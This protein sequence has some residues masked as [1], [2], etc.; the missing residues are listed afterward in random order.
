[1]LLQSKTLEV[2][3]IQN[4]G[5]GLPGS[6]LDISEAIETVG[7]VGF[8]L[9]PELTKISQGS[10]G[11]KLIDDTSGT[12]WNWLQSSLPSGT[13][14]LP[15]F[16]NIIVAGSPVFYGVINIKN[17]DRSIQNGDSS[18]T[19][20]AQDWPNMLGK[21]KLSGE[22]YSRQ[23]PQLQT[24]RVSSS[25]KAGTSVSKYTLLQ[26]TGFFSYASLVYWPGANDWLQEGDTL[27]CD[28]AAGT[29]R[30]MLV[31]TCV[32]PWP[33]VMAPG[34]YTAAFLEGFVW[35]T[36]A[37]TF[38]YYSTHQGESFTGNFTRGSM[39][40][41]AK[42][43]YT[44]L[45]GVP[46]STD[47]VKNNVIKLDT[48]D[49]LVPGD[50]LDIR[51]LFSSKTNAT[52]TVNDIDIERS[53]I[54]TLDPIEVDVSASDILYMTQDSLNEV[55]FEPFKN[56]VAK[57]NT[58]G[59]TDFSR[60]IPAQLST[61]ALSFLPFRLPG[62]AG[63]RLIS[64]SDIHPT[65]AGVMVKGI[66]TM[67]WSGSP[68]AGWTPTT[69][70][71]TAIWTNQ[72]TTAPAYLM[73]DDTI[74][75]APFSPRRN[76]TLLEW[77][78]RNIDYDDGTNTY[79]PADNAIT[80]ASVVYDYSCLRRWRIFRAPLGTAITC[81]QDTWNG[82]SWISATNPTW[83][84][85]P[86]QSM[87]PFAPVASSLGTGYSLLCLDSAG[88]LSV[89]FGASTATLSI[90]SNLWDSILVQTPYGAY[91]VNSRGYGRITYSAGTLTLAYADVQDGQTLSL[92]PTTFCALDANYVYV[93]AGTTLKED[94]G[95]VVN[96]LY[97]FQLL[98]APDS[99][100][101]LKSLVLFEK[102]FN[103]V[104]RLAMAFKDPSSARLLGL[105]GGRLFQIA[106]TL[107]DTIERYSVQ[108]LT[109]QEVI[110][111]VC[112]IHNCMAIPSPS[113]VLQIISR[114]LIEA[115]TNVTV[116]QTSIKQS[117]ISDN[118]FSQVNVSGKDTAINSYIVS[119]NL[120]GTVLE[121]SSHPFI[122][123]TS[124]ARAVA[125][126]Y[127]NFFGKPRRLETQEWIYSN[128]DQI[129]PFQKITINGGSAVWLVMAVNRSLSGPTGS[130]KLLEF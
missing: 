37:N 119:N 6:I 50:K 30:A 34:T 43:S 42:T 61:P 123:T 21:I 109:A 47:L 98:A 82:S 112:M 64:P 27:T 60:F 107:A 59:A 46:K 8:E 83:S 73:P 122:T 121:I 115:P 26:N 76:R 39:P 74:T 2:Y 100:D 110:E 96:E 17:I 38:A 24:S 90:P 19:I 4:L 10:C 128:L 18:I 103:G 66:G 85:V 20:S 113:G 51:A 12:I 67:A 102:I 53:E 78:R 11:L 111:N 120:G 92:I 116:D 89:K 114:T 36:P 86:P 58:V 97:M 63:D 80:L 117:R 44:V 54:I 127:I 57:A 130:V 13:N 48:V 52:F 84:G 5:N 15:P 99:I 23:F 79:N 106:S 65:L 35:P 93:M 49:N 95:K 56:I 16:L 28:L 105:L 88:V 124:Q 126:T 108:G 69:W 72:R 94:T 77:K 104:P 125:D 25:I 45:T 70:S 91:L 118:F 55:V 68:E 129:K 1:M 62:S 75:L 40:A 3:L 29:F 41:T 71:K 9:D 14:L 81:T 87:I 101:P 7:N 33:G 31:Y 22:G 32:N